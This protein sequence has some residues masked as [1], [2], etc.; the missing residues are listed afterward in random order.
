MWCSAGFTLHGWLTGAFLED[1]R[2]VYAA[3]FFF[4]ELTK[5]VGAQLRIVRKQTLGDKNQFYFKM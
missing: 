5:Q 2:V 1:Q 4:I 3:L